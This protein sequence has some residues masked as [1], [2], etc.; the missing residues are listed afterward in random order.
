M[1]AYVVGVIENCYCR[2]TRQFNVCCKKDKQCFAFFKIHPNH[3]MTKLVK[4]WLGNIICM[5]KS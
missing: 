3:I 2:S 1:K 5:W 4:M